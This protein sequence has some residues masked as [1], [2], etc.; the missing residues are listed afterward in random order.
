MWKYACGFAQKPTRGSLIPPA[1]KIGRGA[2]H[3]NSKLVQG[4]VREFV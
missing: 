1:R 4:E 3:K 2:L